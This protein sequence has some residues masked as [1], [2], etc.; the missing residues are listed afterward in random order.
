MNAIAIRF[1]RLRIF[2][3]RMRIADDFPTAEQIAEINARNAPAPGDHV[4]RKV[5]LADLVGRR[6]S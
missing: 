2:L 1:N 3:M 5:S 4:V 6:H